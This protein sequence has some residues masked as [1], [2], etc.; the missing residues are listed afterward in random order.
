MANEADREDNLF[1]LN[2]GNKIDPTEFDVTIGSLLIGLGAEKYIEIFRKKNI[3]QST[4][5]E[6]TE[7]DLCK[8]GV[9]DAEIRRKLI[10][11]VK[12]LPIYEECYEQLSN[13]SNLNP[14]EI[15]DI[16]EASSQHLYRIYL[17]IL[18]NTLALKKT[19]KL[20]D[21]LVYRDKY[22]SDVALTTLS[23]ITN[24]LNS[25]DIALH[26]QIK[27]LTKESSNNIKRKKIIVATVGT[28]VIS[29]LTLMFVRSIK[30]LK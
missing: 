8:L 12:D 30:D 27:D 15:V 20:Q 1:N 16:F 6:L 17:S 14:I 29:I 3:G 9:D 7:E 19:K 25:M 28:A 26:T 24:I 18:A 23:E 10:E 13:K 5:M 11:V 4:L 2:L 22:A 21:C